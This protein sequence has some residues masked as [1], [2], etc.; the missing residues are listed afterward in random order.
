MK[1]HLPPSMG[2]SFFSGMFVSLL[3]LQYCFDDLIKC[4]LLTMVECN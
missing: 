2:R 4:I 1:L 3:Y